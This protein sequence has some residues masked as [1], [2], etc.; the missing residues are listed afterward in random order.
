M[1]GGGRSSSRLRGA[2]LPKRARTRPAVARKGTKKTRA[3]I[4]LTWAT[5]WMTGEK[6]YKRPWAPCATRRRISRWCPSPAGR[7]RAHRSAARRSVAGRAPSAGRSRADPWGRGTPTP[8]PPRRE[9][10][11][12]WSRQRHTPKG[13]RGPLVVVTPLGTTRTTRAP[14]APAPRAAPRA[15]WT[16]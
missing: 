9:R 5:G 10:R 12:R 2:D 8:A 3:G 16:H 1:R 11:R 15:L 7:R 6:G 13:T 4:L 14:A